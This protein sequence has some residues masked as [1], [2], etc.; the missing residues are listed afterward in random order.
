M[1]AR[2]LILS[3][4]CCLLIFVYVSAS[5]NMPKCKHICRQNP[6]NSQHRKYIQCNFMYYNL[7]YKCMYSNENYIALLFNVA[8]CNCRLLSRILCTLLRIFNAVLKAS[9]T[10]I[11]VTLEH[12]PL[13][14]QPVLSINTKHVRTTSGIITMINKIKRNCGRQAVSQNSNS[15]FNS[16]L[17]HYV[18]PQLFI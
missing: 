15:M 3:V 5:H 2:S 6:D 16:L 18:T 11:S 7:F 17:F 1:C 12:Q 4:T 13:H 8:Y 14:I 9:V 10:G